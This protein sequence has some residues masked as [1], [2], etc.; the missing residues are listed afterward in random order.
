VTT[1]PAT[2]TAGASP[3]CP[4]CGEPVASGDVFCEA[5]GQEL[6]APS[7]GPAVAP[8]PTPAAGSPPTT[9]APGPS[10]VGD[11][12]APAAGPR[13]PSC[14]A[15]EI[16]PDGYCGV[17]GMKQPAAHDHEE[18]VIA[19]VAA[20]TDRGRH[21]HRNEDAMAI[22]RRADGPLV[23][24]VCDGVSMT[25][26]PDKA[27]A[28]AVAAALEVL[29]SAD[30]GSA[31]AISEALLAAHVAAR[32]AVGAVPFMPDANLGS[33]SCTF[34]AAVVTPPGR[35]SL[36]GL[37]DCR[38]YWLDRAAGTD[39][40]LTADDSW[41]AEEVAEHALPAD[42]AYADPRAHMITRWIGLD[43]DPAWRPALSRFD[44][45]HGRLLLC[46]DGLWNYTVE[47]GQL[48]TAAAGDDMGPAATAR[49]L[50]AF[51]NDRGG[52]D[53]ITVVL[54]DLP[55]PSASA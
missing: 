44:A 28:A 3:V 9:P 20:V 14:G 23:A 50:V 38:A 1:A 16:T 19:G 24:V 36:A 37:G 11:G 53:N 29:T 6:P 45:D 49:R 54:V 43:A 26:N 22:A 25:V 51:A 40:V 47:P 34:L 18:V 52:H 27:S 39:R 4:H 48:T 31:G 10:P 55:L 7:A 5:C 13:C 35:I 2:D 21:H 8:A 30:L 32:G 17:C 33:P 46:S 41:A 42:K 15:D 12:G